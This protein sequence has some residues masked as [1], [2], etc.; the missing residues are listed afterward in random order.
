MINSLNNYYKCKDED[1]ILNNNHLSLSVGEISQISIKSTYSSNVRFTTTNSNVVKVNKSGE[2]QAINPGKAS[3]VVSIGKYK[4]ECSIVVSNNDFY[5]Y[6]G[7]MNGK[8]SDLNKIPLQ[9]VNGLQIK[10][11]LGDDIVILLPENSEYIASK[12]DGNG[13]KICF[14]DCN[15]LPVTI[16]G[17]NYKCYGESYNN[18]LTIYIN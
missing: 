11:K 14:E 17:V 5:I 12:D 15:G 18:E 6:Y 2:I 1:I 3:I 16:E 8:I 13:N 7:V 9:P 4:T 10:S